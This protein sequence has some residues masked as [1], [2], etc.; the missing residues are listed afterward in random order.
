MA[1]FE[2][3]YELGGGYDNKVELEIRLVTKPSSEDIIEL[4]TAIETIDKFAKKN[5]ELRR[6]DNE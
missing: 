4:L 1:N 2:I 3:K 5:L 6:L